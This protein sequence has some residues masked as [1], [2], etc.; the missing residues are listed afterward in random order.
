MVV[1]TG[2][3]RTG[4]ARPLPHGAASSESGWSPIAA[5]KPAQAAG[6]GS[7]G[8]GPAAMVSSG[9]VSTSQLLCA[10]LAAAQLAISTA[11]G[12]T[13]AETRVRGIDLDVEVGIWGV[14]V[15]SS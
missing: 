15:A 5:L 3:R 11:G 7:P 1:E 2:G 9:V 10:L 4:R 6:R 13:G 8:Y 12:C 14:E